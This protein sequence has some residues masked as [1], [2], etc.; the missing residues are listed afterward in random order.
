MLRGMS[1]IG[2]GM[3]HAVFGGAVVSYVIGFNYYL[4]ATIWGFLS[5]G[6][7]KRN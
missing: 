3:S 2:H 5:A 1:Y 7:Y 6:T 4:G